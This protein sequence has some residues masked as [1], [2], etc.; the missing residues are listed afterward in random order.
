[1]VES[2]VGR[3]LLASGGMGGALNA[4]FS[5]SAE[6]GWGPAILHREWLKEWLPLLLVPAALIGAARA[7]EL[8]RWRYSAYVAL[9]IAICAGLGGICLLRVLNNVADPPDW[10]VK[11]FWL[12]GRVAAGGGGFYDPQALRAIATLSQLHPEDPLFT[13]VVLNAGFHYPPPTILLL[14]PF[15]LMNLR[16]ATAAW[17]LVHGSAFLAAVV[18][19]WRTFAREQGAVG[20]ALVGALVFALRPTY[21]TFAFGQ[22][23]FIILLLLVM[24]CRSRAAGRGLW[25][26]A[27]MAV[28]P[29]GVVLV[30]P[31]ALRREWRSLVAAVITL[32]VLVI[33]TAAFFGIQPF[34]AYLRDNPVSRMPRF[35]F[36]LDE[37]Q[38]LLAEVLRVGHYDLA[39]TPFWKVS[40]FLALAAV[41]S[42]L[43][44]WLLVKLPRDEWQLAL[45]LAVT[46]ALLLYPL[47]WEHYGVLL[48]L[49]I[50]MLWTRREELELSTPF[51]IALLTATYALVRYHQGSVALWGTL[52]MYGALLSMGARLILRNRVTGARFV[53][54]WRLPAPSLATPNG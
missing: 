31:L 47:S 16:L 52:L 40:E 30:A 25:L 49:P 22:T 9:L 37:N 23:N 15:G 1:M 27:S 48:I 29:L 43:A 3:L 53:A 34:V 44:G 50:L 21:T 35:I 4:F 33:I 8:T 5:H 20:L 17:Y 18:L 32:A 41:I 19:L 39:V 46:V 36:T 54:P 10:D 45:A 13:E 24:S 7:R 51:V 38:S 2:L 11:A 42:A 28:K 26:A 6:V 14:A 12:F